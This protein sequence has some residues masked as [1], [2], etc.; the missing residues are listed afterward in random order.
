MYIRIICIIGRDNG[1]ESQYLVI[2]ER[3]KEIER[4]SNTK[5]KSPAERYWLQK[6]IVK[7]YKDLLQLDIV[8]FLKILDDA[9]INCQLCIQKKTFIFFI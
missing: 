7:Y 4:V 3:N 5:N 9:F 8:L 2:N 6:C 1:K